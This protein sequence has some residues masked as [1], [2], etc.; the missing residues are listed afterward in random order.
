MSLIHR[1]FQP[2]ALKEKLM[3]KDFR[4]QKQKFN[5]QGVIGGFG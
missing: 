5:N 4:R 3:P 1:F 2:A